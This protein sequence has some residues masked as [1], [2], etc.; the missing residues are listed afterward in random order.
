MSKE[1]LNI[2]KLR[3]MANP[4]I[5]IPNFD[6][7]GTINVKVQRP[8]LMAMA[9][10]GQIPNHLLG[11]ATQMVSGKTGNK[12]KK[13]KEEDKL[14]EAALMMEL[15]CE[16]CLV[17]PSY[18]E[19]KDIMTDQ[20]SDAIFRFAMGEVNTLDT[21]RKDEADDKHDTDGES[22]SEKAE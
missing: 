17:E 7:T 19:F 15:Y 11:I 10:K 21:F 8:R 22:I 16:A 9:A 12:G 3:E 14:K 20:Q 2:E 18:A 6:N 1:I 4:I 5:S 13:E